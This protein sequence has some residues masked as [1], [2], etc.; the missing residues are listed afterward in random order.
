MT[1]IIQKWLQL[2]DQRYLLAQ[3]IGHGFGKMIKLPSK[4]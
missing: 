3:N 4:V 1:R 2:Q